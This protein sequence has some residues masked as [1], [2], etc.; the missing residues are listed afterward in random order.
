M[1][2]DAT[3]GATLLP[4]AAL[5]IGGTDIWPMAQTL[6]AI[7]GLSG[8][9]LF[10]YICARQPHLKRPLFIAFFLIGAVIMFVRGTATNMWMVVIPSM[11][12][13]LVTVAIYVPGYTIVRD[14][15]DRKTAGIFLGFVAMM[16]GIALLIGP[17]LAGFIAEYS[18][19]RYMFFISAT[20]MVITALLMIG[21][22][23]VTKEEGLRL[24]AVSGKFDAVGAVWITIFLSTLICLLSMTN[25]IPLGSPFS[26][27]LMV[28]CVIS[29]IFLVRVIR[30]KK[31]HAILPA[32]VL[33]D[34]NTRLL[35]LMNTIFT[36]SAMGPS[37]F[38]PTYMMFVMGASPSQAGI[39]ASVYAIAGIVIGPWIGK[40][41][42]VRGTAREVVMFGSMLRLAVQ[43]TL[44]FFV[45][46][47]SPLWYVYIIMGIGG[48]YSAIGGVMPAVAPQIQLKEEVRILGNSIVQ[49]GASLGPPIGISIFTAIITN[50]GPAVGF[51]IVLLLTSLISILEFIFAVPLKK[52][53]GEDL[54]RSEAYG[55]GDGT[56]SSEGSE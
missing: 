28:A 40:M 24:A 50:M 29:L 44:F 6:P 23:R 21:G 47:D 27:I 30:A 17:I 43:L 38:L 32:H 46:P 45:Q 33:K 13:V 26:I 52:L 55:Q 8:M 19:W 54:K 22:V 16:Q 15:Y 12:F 48:I 36:F 37:V 49:M 35:F 39:A 14:M 41:M 42:A 4:Q 1:I 51:K 7:F 20:L 2:I 3:G 11:F 53:E 34:K 10:G 5:E 56:E 25:Y 18:N 31:E 9:A